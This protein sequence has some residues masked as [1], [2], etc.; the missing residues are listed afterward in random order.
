MPKIYRLEGQRFGRWTVIEQ[1]GVDHRGE[2]LY[3]CQCDCGNVGVVRS[4]SLRDGRSSSCG[5]FANELTS[6][7]S[8][9]HGMT[10]TRLF[11]IWSGMRS[12]CYSTTDYH[13][14]W[15]GARG[16]TMCDEW[17]NDF[18]TFYNWAISSG[19]D[20]GLSIDRIDN[21][22]NYEPSNCRWTTHAEQMRNQGRNIMLTYNGKTL[23]AMDWSRETGL[24][25]ATIRWRKNK[26]GWSDEKTLTTPAFVPETVSTTLTVNGETKTIQEWSKYSKISPNVIKHRIH[27]GWDATSAVMEPIDY[28]KRMRGGSLVD[29][30]PYVSVAKANGISDSTYR[31]RV[32]KGMSSEEAASKPLRGRQGGSAKYGKDMLFEIEGQVRTFEEWGKVYGIRWESIYRRLKRGIDPYSAITK[33]LRE[34]H[35]KEESQ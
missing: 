24:S 8:K 32:K 18:Q 6:K 16:I 11:N 1:C 22:G 7:R 14:K 30:D 3:R 27:S 33:P 19:Y 20:D 2:K 9:T 4:S 17:K 21:N 35:K 28:K 23:C 25:D 13:Y 34:F 5:C 31:Y 10:N 12:R 26:L 29:V 15:Y